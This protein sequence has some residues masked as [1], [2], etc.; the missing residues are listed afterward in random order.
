MWHSME[1]LAHLPYDEGSCCL[2]ENMLPA[3]QGVQ[4]WPPKG[5]KRTLFINPPHACTSGL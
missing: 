5:E 1:S 2:L 3:S 4:R